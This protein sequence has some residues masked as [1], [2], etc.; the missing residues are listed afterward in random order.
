MMDLIVCALFSVIKGD[1]LKGFPFLLLHTK[2]ASIPLARSCLSPELLLR[3][4]IIFSSQRISS[5]NVMMWDAMQCE[6]RDLNFSSNG[7]I[8]FGKQHK[9]DSLIALKLNGN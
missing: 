4:L 7:L 5:Q 3:K 8:M 6:N 2:T 9:F 1:N